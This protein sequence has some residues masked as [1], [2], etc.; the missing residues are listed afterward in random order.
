MH[1]TILKDMHE[2]RVVAGEI[3]KSLA[4]PILPNRPESL[5][6]DRAS[7]PEPAMIPKGWRIH[8]PSL[9][10]TIVDLILYPPYHT[11]CMLMRP[12]WHPVSSR[13]PPLRKGE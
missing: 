4:L 3:F 6:S 11:Y 2:G 12:L 7:L 10:G 5:S 8:D 13:F 9:F 1:S